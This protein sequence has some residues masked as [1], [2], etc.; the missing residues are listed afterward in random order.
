M[1]TNIDSKYNVIGTLK[2]VKPKTQYFLWKWVCY[3]EFIVAVWPASVIFVLPARRNC[4]GAGEM[5]ME[6]LLSEIVC[7]EYDWTINLTKTLTS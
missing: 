1:G 4:K 5:E 6:I 2:I 3:N 7:V